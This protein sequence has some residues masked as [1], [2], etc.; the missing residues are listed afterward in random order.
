MSPTLMGAPVAAV[1]EPEEP[2]E[3]V[4]A[5]DAAELAVVPLEAGLLLDEHAPTAAAT[6]STAATRATFDPVK[7]LPATGTL[8]PVCRFVV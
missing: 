7:D 4:V 2:V 1:D 5:D 3:A 8:H 6:P